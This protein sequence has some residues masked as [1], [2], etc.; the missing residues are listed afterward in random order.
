MGQKVVALDTSVFIYVLEA[1]PVYAHPAMALLA[2]IRD[3]AWSGVFASV[4][5]IELLT[6]PKQAGRVDLAVAYERHLAAF[7]N[8][9]IAPL[10][11]RVIWLA[12]DLRAKYGIR[13]PDAIHLATALA[14]GADE[15]ITNDKALRKVQ[16]LS[17][18]MV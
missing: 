4:G 15:F 3:G 14:A 6:G 8:L 13:T 5:M 10:S 1:H 9:E 7:P 2:R 16:E 11:E 17:V 12:S 18:V